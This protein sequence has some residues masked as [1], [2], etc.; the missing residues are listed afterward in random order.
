MNLMFDILH[1]KYK[2]ADFLPRETT[3][4]IDLFFSHIKAR[5][6]GSL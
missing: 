6:R 4:A 3:R 1:A 2:D 5:L